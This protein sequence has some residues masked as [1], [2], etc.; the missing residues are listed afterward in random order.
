MLEK[1]LMI[2]HQCRTHSPAASHN[3]QH[4]K[5]RG[6]T[7]I[8][9]SIALVVMMIVGLSITSLFVYAINNN[10]GSNDRELALGVA[11]QRMEQLRNIPFNIDNSN[12]AL[13]NGGLGAT[14]V[15]GVVEPDVTMGGRHYR[16][17]TTITNLA[18]DAAAVVPTMKRITIQVTPSGA[19]TRLGSVTLTSLRTT[20]VKGTN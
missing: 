11:Q 18:F 10:S 14:A 17:V 4:S 20:V 9:T 3:A 2:V 12:L 7:L 8:E 15:T 6:F 13:A 16:V 5:E 1:K 19:G